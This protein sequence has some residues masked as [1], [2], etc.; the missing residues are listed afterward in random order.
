VVATRGTEQLILSIKD[1]YVHFQ[2]YEGIS[3]VLDGV[4]LEVPAGSRVG[5]VGETGCGKTV[6]MKTVMGTLKSPP[7]LFP[8][9]E[10][11]LCGRDVLKMTR[12]EIRAM[13]GSVVSMIFQDPLSALNPVF[14]IGEQLRDII[15]QG[16]KRSGGSRLTKQEVEDKQERALD[17]V[18]LPDIKRILFCYPFELSGGMRQRALIAMSLVNQPRFLIADEP[19]TAL[20]VTVQA[21]I[22]SL[23]A[24]LV[25]DQ[26]LSL[27]F[28]SHNLG[29]IR[30]AVDSVYIMY[31][32]QIVESGSVKDVL[33]A[34]LHPYTIGLLACVP[35]LTG[36]RKAGGIQGTIP[37]YTEAPSGCRFY[38][39]CEHSIAAC[40]QQTPKVVECSPGHKISCHLYE[41]KPDE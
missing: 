8:R 32:G 12:R 4:S 33:D 11:L 23:L 25:Q 9:G 13:K 14:T 1:L 36:E 21:Q 31:A 35:R 16:R 19:G 7:A 41:R 34:P 40:H 6:T 15:R 22:L 39:R 3:S 5:L 20:D 18:R 24:E 29:V 30:E 26:E 38:P 17:A 37:D 2:T 27:M 10:V 28:I